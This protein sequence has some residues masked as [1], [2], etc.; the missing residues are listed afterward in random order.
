M[1]T[2]NALLLPTGK[3]IFGAATERKWDVLQAFRRDTLPPSQPTHFASEDGG[4][5]LRNAVE[6]WLHLT[7]VTLKIAFSIQVVPLLCLPIN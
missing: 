2:D 7:Q 6:S 1:R 4:M 3:N 5:F